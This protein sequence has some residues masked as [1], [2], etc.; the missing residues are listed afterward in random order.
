MAAIR[1]VAHQSSERDELSIVRKC[2]V[3][4]CRGISLRNRENVQ[5]ESATKGYV[6]NINLRQALEQSGRNVNVCKQEEEIVV[7]VV[8]VIV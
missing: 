4:R 6:W 8:L 3:I 2:L 5:G 1:R 7:S